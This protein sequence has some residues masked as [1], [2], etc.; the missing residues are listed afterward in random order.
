MLSYRIEE[1]PMGHSMTLNVPEK[2]YRVLIQK[3]EE[4]GQEPESLAVQFLTIAIQP[5]ADDPV[6]AFIGALSSHGSDWAD[7]H[8]AYLGSALK[9]NMGR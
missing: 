8:D 6:E 5:G 9:D 4:A 3:A 1:R 2:V 7:Q